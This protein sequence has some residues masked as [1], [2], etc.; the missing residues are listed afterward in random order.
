MPLGTEVDLGPDHIVLDWD[1]A[2]PPPVRGTAAPPLFGLFLFCGQTV[3]HLSCSALVRA[4]FSD[5]LCKQ[6]LAASYVRESS[7]CS[8]SRFQFLSSHEMFRELVA[9]C[10]Q[11]A[12][13]MAVV[14]S[15]GQKCNFVAQ[16]DV[17]V[18]VNR[19]LFHPRSHTCAMS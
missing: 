13:V 7:S 9:L 5:D 16:N 15:C 12:G 19:F 10:V 14:D 11:K 3:A 17:V 1:P 8:R 18:T 6:R 2:P 4:F